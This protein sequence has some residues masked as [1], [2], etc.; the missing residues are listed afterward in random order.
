M[1]A[2]FVAGAVLGIVANSVPTAASK[3]VTVQLIRRCPQQRDCLPEKVVRGMKDETSKIWSL[4]D[5]RID[6]IESRG[7]PNLGRRRHGPAGGE[8]RADA[9]A[10]FDERRGPGSAPFARYTLRNWRGTSV[11]HTSEALRGRDTRCSFPELA[12]HALRPVSLTCARARLGSRDRPLSARDVSAHGARSHASALPA[13][14][15]PR[16][17]NTPALRSG[18]GRPWR[19]AFVS[20]C[21]GSHRRCLE[22]LTCSLPRPRAR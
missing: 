11:G 13:V 15:A 18:S 21:R 6:W 8:C 16:I 4:L 20:T 7:R 10:V 22:S 14:G 5:V 19:S 9:S 1:L 3:S 17:R 12:A 2:A